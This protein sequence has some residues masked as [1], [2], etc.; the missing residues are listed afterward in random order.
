MHLFRGALT[1][2]ILLLGLAPVTSAA[3]GLT[4]LW[5]PAATA[6]GATSCTC[7]GSTN[8]SLSCRWATRINTK[9][10]LFAKSM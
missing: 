1:V 9:L 3:A 10:R 5:R 6:L 4:K 8:P 7:P 2:L